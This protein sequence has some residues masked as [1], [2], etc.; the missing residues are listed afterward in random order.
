MAE[1]RNWPGHIDKWTRMMEHILTS[2]GF[3]RPASTNQMY[4]NGGFLAGRVKD[5]IQ[6]F[7]FIAMKGFDDDQALLG[8]YLLQYPDNIQLDYFSE[9][10]GTS[11]RNYIDFSNFEAGCRF[12]WEETNKQFLKS[13]TISIPAFL[14]FPG[15]NAICFKKLFDRMYASGRE[16]YNLTRAHADLVQSNLYIEEQK[17][18]E[19]KKKVE[20]AAVP[21]KGRTDSKKKGSGGVHRETAVERYDRGKLRGKG[22][23]E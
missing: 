23:E 13:D 2:E 5:L 1:K 21:K 4:P 3:D 9:L 7:E 11:D 19:E 18:R 14:H 17:I 22:M 20:D 6:V 12:H 15:K 16:I 8:E 10:F